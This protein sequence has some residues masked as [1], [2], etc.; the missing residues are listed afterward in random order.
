M[1]Q[2][3]KSVD[4]LEKQEIVLHNADIVELIWKKMM[5]TE[6]IQYSNALKVQF[7]HLPRI[8]HQVLQDIASQ[9]PLLSTTNFCQTSEI[10]TTL[11]NSAEATF[12]QTGEHDFKG[13]LFI[14]KYPFTKWTDDLLR[15]N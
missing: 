1:S 10:S 13:K 14:G 6:L 8:Y 9:V 12:P 11:E 15:P 5:N 4:R 7:Q 3:V 2:F